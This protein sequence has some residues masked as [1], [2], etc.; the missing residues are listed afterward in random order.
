MN[1]LHKEREKLLSL[2]R[3]QEDK[4]FLAKILDK[5]ALSQKTRQGQV[6]DFLDPHHQQLAVTLAAQAAEVE[7]LMSGG[8]PQAE[9]QRLVVYPKFMPVEE[10]DDRIECLAVSGNFRFQ[11]VNHRDYLGS[12]LGLGLKREKFGDILVLEEGAQLL[13]D[14]EVADYLVL[15]LAKIHRVPVQVQI[16]PRNQL[17]LPAG[18]TKQIKATVASLRIDAIAAAGFGISRTQMVGA[19]A[20]EKLKLNWQP[21]LDPAKPVQE[22]DILSLRG[23]GRVEVTLI[24]GNT[25]KGRISLVLNRFL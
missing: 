24:S 11:K 16:I 18:Q 17:A 14:R 12:I 21:I 9:R 4:L 8:Y 1:M 22:G 2:G 10:V 19:I 13:A 15:N 23:Q 3:S 7:Y 20:A 6:S 5:M 25:K